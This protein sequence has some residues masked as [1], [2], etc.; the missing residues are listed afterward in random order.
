MREKFDFE[1]FGQILFS[2][3]WVLADA[4]LALVVILFARALIATIIH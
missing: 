2:I 3:F 4:F 1:K